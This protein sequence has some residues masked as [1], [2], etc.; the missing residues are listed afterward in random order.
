[1]KNHEARPTK[2]TSFSEMNAA[3]CNFKRGYG[4]GHNRRRGRGNQ[5]RNN[6]FLKYEEPNSHPKLEKVEEQ[7]R[8]KKC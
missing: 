7:I 2:S 6:Y 5:V 3:T 4:G 1:M 8:T